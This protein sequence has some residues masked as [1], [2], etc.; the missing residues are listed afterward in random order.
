MTNWRTISVKCWFS[1]W[2]SRDKTLGAR[3]CECGCVFN[4]FEPIETI[5]SSPREPLKT[6]HRHAT[7]TRACT[8]TSCCSTLLVTGHNVSL[9]SIPFVSIL[10]YFLCLFCFTYLSGYSFFS[11][12][13]CSTV[14][15]HF[16]HVEDGGNLFK[17]SQEESQEKLDAFFQS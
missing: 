12:A 3:L 1:L 10:C 2:D 11:R 14:M 8:R 9:F 7:H 13:D 15:S 17:C 4:L 6:W 5:N 16:Q